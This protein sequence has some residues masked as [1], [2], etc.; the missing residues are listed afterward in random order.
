MRRNGYQVAVVGATGAVGE[1]MLRLF[2]ERDFPISTLRVFASHRS[3]GQDV[4]CGKKRILVEDLEKANLSG[5][6][7]ALFS[8]GSKTAQHV[9]PRFVKAGAVVIDN[10]SAFRMDDDVPLI[11]PEVNAHALADYRKRRIIANPNCSTIQ[12][13]VAL[14]PLHDAATVKRIVVSTYQAVSGAGRRAMDELSSQCV[15]LFNQRELKRTILPQQIAFNC[16]PQIGAFTD[17]GYTEEEIKMVNETKKIM[18]APDIRVIATCVR[19]P[20]FC[21]H[22]EAV[23]VEFERSISVSEA[24]ERL[25]A[26]PGVAVVDNPEKGSYPMPIDATGKDATLVGRIR[27]D[28]T[29]PNGL[30]FWIVA[31]NL[32]KGAA[33]NA[34]QIAELLIEQ[35]DFA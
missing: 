33:L 17:D 19:V 30:A 18:S 5:I 23:I 8:A 13:V 34:V 11:V 16:F 25:M 22:S 21:S 20:I 26:A 1:E 29:V 24:R 12:L 10:S 35:D 4:E 28:N 7:I 2:D 14:K 15:D 3:V 32:R 9:A 31:D 6:E 27:K